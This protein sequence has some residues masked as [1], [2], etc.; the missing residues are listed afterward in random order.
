MKHQD[1]L[2]PDAL[3]LALAD[4]P[5]W[6]FEATRSALTRQFQFTSFAE[7]FGFMAE[8]ALQAERHDHHPEWFNVYNR[9]DVTW[10]SHDVQGVSARD[11]AMARLCDG[12][13]ARRLHPSAR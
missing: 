1:R 5:L 2:D 10:T 13:A 8:I 9:V 7:A 3:R 4:L 12:A 11:V 6:T